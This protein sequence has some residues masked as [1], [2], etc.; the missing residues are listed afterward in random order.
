MLC[1]GFLHALAFPP[2]DLAEAA[3]VF[4]VPLLLWG[5]FGR[6]FPREGLFLF[7][8]G[9][10]TW[11]V[12]V[13]WLRNFTRH[14]E[15][16]MAEAV[17]WLAML[18]LSFLL[19][20]FWWIWGRVALAVVRRVRGRGIPWRLMVV[21]GLAG[22]WVLLE[23]VRGTILTGFPWLPLAASQWQRPLLLQIA[24]VTGSGAV[25]FILVAFNVG[26][27]LYLFLLW[28]NRRG[29]WFQ[30]LSFEFYLALALLFGAIAYG[31]HTSGA[32]RGGR[33]DGPRLGFVQP[34]AGAMEKWDMERMRE[35]LD[36]LRDLT[37]LVSY[38]KPGLI[39]WP[40]SPTP[41]PVK[42][43]AS[44]RQWVESLSREVQLPLLIGNVAREGGAQDP[45]RKWF[46]A[47]F[48]ANPGTGLETD[49]YYAKRHL[50]PFGEYVPRW[51]PFI[52]K[53]VP[54]EAEFFPG[55]SAAPVKMFHQGESLGKAG[56]LICYEDIFPRLAREN[57]LAGAEWHYVATNNVWYGE[58]AGAWQHAAHSVLRAV[59][60]RRPVVRC[61]NAGWSGW[62][63]EF[64][65]IRH[66]ML[67]EDRSIYFQGVE[68]VDFSLSAF[69]A[70]KLSPYVRRGDWF[71]AGCGLLSCLLF[72]ARSGRRFASG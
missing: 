63:D 7:L 9:W 29:S 21:P 69:W 14:L 32:G 49:H 5:L 2:F 60:T 45:S 66:V 34:Y 19:A 22:F 47:V 40:E 67:D 42:G 52:D 17:G 64:G 27:S 8:G 35:N 33:L 25:S 71:I 65:H 41:L 55:K 23:W 48:F 3:Y 46:N 15:F 72:P 11:I 57:T 31:L 38:L 59:E 62:I 6:P 10:L 68:A 30:R 58:E 70:G 61:G 37:I 54:L 1:S 26:I 36:T 44:M 28:K 4:A 18:A 56:I 13:F 16:P 39:L 43:N 24:S 20:V 53:V 12:L 51:I 50:V